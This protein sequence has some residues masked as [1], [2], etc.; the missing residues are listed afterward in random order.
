MAEETRQSPDGPIPVRVL[1]EGPEA[2]GQF[3][4]AHADGH[5]VGLR[6]SGT[7]TGRGRVIVR[8][9]AS[10]V[11]SFPHIARICGLTAEDRIWIPGPMGSTMNLFAA[12]LAE[13]CGAA[14]TAHDAGSSTVWQVTPAVLVRLLDAGLPAS[15]RLRTTIVAGDGLSRGLRDRA[16]AQGVRIV[17]YYGAAEMSMIA[18]GSCA[19]DL[20]VFNETEV[21]IGDGRIWVRSPWLSKGY[22]SSA[23][24]APLMIDAEGFATVGDRGELDGRRLKVFGRDGAV[25]TAGQTVLLAPLQERLQAEARG[26]VFL[27]GCPHPSIGQVLTA[28]VTDGVD[29]P[30][31]RS[32]ARRHLDG[33]DRPRRWECVPAPPLTPS[34]K[35]DLRALRAA[36]SQREGVL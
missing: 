24:D 36:L 30:V 10:W 4:D 6:T 32:W 23:T 2:V 25:T 26:E 34:G 22:L 18:V 35:V 8:T 12:C 20:A 1:D 29:L 11:G 16:R 33:A 31:L 7:S 19:D 13:S 14:W 9:T 15:R 21:R 3:W 28:V 17:H 27:L 5:L